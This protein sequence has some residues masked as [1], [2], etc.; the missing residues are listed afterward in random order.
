MESSENRFSQI[1]ATISQLFR[2]Y[3]ETRARVPPRMG[4]VAT[5]SWDKTKMFNS[6]IYWSKG[7]L[8]LRP[9]DWGL[10]IN[11]FRSEKF[12]RNILEE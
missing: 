10:A 12:F 8:N 5:T 1:P 9:L 6:K 2:N 7:E 3:F 11:R 4:L